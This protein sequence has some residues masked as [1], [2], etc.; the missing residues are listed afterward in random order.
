MEFFQASGD[1][2]S[3]S[4][5]S[6]EV[7]TTKKYWKLHASFYCCLARKLLQLGETR[8]KHAIALETFC[9]QC[10]S[11]LTSGQQFR[12]QMSPN[13][14]NF[15]HRI[16]SHQMKIDKYFLHHRV[17]LVK[18]VRNIPTLS[19]L[20][21]FW[22]Y[23]QSMEKVK[24]A[25]IRVNRSCC[26]SEDAP[27]WNKHIGTRFKSQSQRNHKLWTKCIFALWRHHLTSEMTF[28]VVAD[29]NLHCGHQYTSLGI[30]ILNY[31]NTSGSI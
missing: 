16:I 27:W 20:G 26:K 29:A 9:L 4:S 23:A 21:Q 11:D 3:T 30:V 10:F 17:P 25:K 8:K 5:G 13:V 31:L 24:D 6:N 18:A 1:L 2:R 14:T 22:F 19:P 15:Q 28:R 12:L 7:T